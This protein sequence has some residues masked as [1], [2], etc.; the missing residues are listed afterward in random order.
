MRFQPEE[1]EDWLD[2]DRSSAA[3]RRKKA[4]GASRFPNLKSATLTVDQKLDIAASEADASKKDAST[5]ETSG[6]K[7]IDTLKVSLVEGAGHERAPG[8]C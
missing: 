5:V 6:E 3:G 1:A 4:K 2:D 7:L 8:D